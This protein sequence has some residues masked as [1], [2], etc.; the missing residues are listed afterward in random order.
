MR[1]FIAAILLIIIV[2]SVTAVTAFMTDEYAD[3]LISAVAEAYSAPAENR[4]YAVKNIDSVWEE[5]RGVVSV[6]IHRKEVTRTDTLI[7]ALS[8]L[9]E[10]E[11]TDAEFYGVCRQLEE[12]FRHIREHCTPSFYN[13]M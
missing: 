11:C 6:T 3:R 10:R 13:V 8:E 7:S 12:E 9:C 2:V 1:S 4:A 5:A